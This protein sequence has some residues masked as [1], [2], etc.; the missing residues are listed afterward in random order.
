MADPV[1]TTAWQARLSIIVPAYNERDG[2]IPTLTSLRAVVPNAEIIVIDDGSDDDTG[3]QAATVADVRVEQHSFNRGY[4]AALKTGMRLASRDYVAWFDSDNEHRTEDLCKMTERLHGS[5]LVAVIGQRSSGPSHFRSVGKWVIRMF[6]R[7]LRLNAGPDLN[8]GLRVFRRAVIQPYIALLPN[9]YSASMTSTMI[10]IERGYPFAFQPIELG[11]RIGKSKLVLG[12]GLQALALVA[13]MAMLFAPLRIFL[14]VGISL[15]LIGTIY[16]IVVAVEGRLG[17][18]VLSVVLT[19]AG[20]IMILQ[21]LIADQIS[22]MRL[23]QLEN[24]MAKDSSS[25]TRPPL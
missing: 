6:A 20:V 24:E 22:Y 18:P 4:G 5:R 2:I 3:A 17:L 8:C 1:S 21:G 13:R 19:L 23:S 12:D 25:V 10:L 16:G 7:W 14:P 11:A 15:S 9:R